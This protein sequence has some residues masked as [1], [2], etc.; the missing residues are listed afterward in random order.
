MRTYLL[1]FIVAACAACGEPPEWPLSAAQLDSVRMALTACANPWAAAIVYTAGGTVSRNGNN[2]RANW[3]TQGDDPISHSGPANSGQPWT[4]LGPCQQGTSKPGPTAPAAPTAPVQ[5]PPSHP[6]DS[7][8]QK[9]RVFFS[10]YKDATISANWNTSVISTNVTGSLT[11][12]LQVPAG[13]PVYTWAFATGEC[14]NENWGGI[15]GA[16][17]AQ[18][19]VAGFVAAKK[20]YV[21]STGGAAGAFT[22]GSDAAFATFLDRYDSDYLRG[23]DFDIEAGQSQ[24]TIDALVGRVKAAQQNPKYKDLRFSFTIATLGGN[25]KPSL[26]ATG[27]QVVQSVQRAGLKDYFINL[28]AMD[29]GSTTAGNCTIGADGKCDM[30]ASANQAATS[31]HNQMGVPYSQ[32]ELTPMVGGND[33]QDETFTLAD[34]DTVMAF[35]KKQGLGG[36]HYW[37]LDRDTDSPPGYAS[38]IANSYGKAG[39]L[40]FLKRFLA[41]NK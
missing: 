41:G 4:A 24:A 7:A 31:L 5:A 8:P 33:T 39:T 9:G 26:G 19:N 17:L 40:G 34:V 12:L 36:V 23:V 28:M 16:T 18:A 37:S 29:Y 13:A 20:G 27:V 22:C 1:T 14:G 32:I 11:P 2:Y 30:G 6:V 21:L 25:A 38:P 3:W 35:A 15:P 10:P